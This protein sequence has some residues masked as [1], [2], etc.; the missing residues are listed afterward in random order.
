M[1]KH[2][3]GLLK[4]DKGR[5]W[6]DGRDIAMM[7]G[8]ELEK[9]R[10]LFGM[11]FQNA[12][13]FDDMTV[14]DNV[15]FPLREHT[16]LTEAEIGRKLKD[17]LTLLGMHDGYNKFPNEL[18]GGMKKRVGLA[19]AIIREPSVLLYD[20]PTT[21]L[22]PVTRTTVDNLIETM[23]RELHLTSLVISH[24]IPSALLLADMIAFLHQGEI[25]FWGEPPAFKK[26]D[27]PAI[28]RFLDAE[29]RT[30]LALQE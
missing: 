27:H 1:L 30:V 19:R 21:G 16:K 29:Q 28:K 14:F 23:K 6:V 10:L 2:I 26:A 5:I 12:A 9:H 15:A 17:T 4:P 20:E 8:R 18:S 13:L 11:V 3:M 24:D 25:V 22:D 7:R